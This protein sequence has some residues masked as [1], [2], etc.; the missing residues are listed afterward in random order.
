M[1]PAMYWTPDRSAVQW[2]EAGWEENIHSNVRQPWV[3]TQIKCGAT[4]S[5]P[6]AIVIHGEGERR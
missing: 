2:S 3:A 6:T 5:A 1:V 4:T